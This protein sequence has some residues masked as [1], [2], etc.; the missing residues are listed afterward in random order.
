MADRCTHAPQSGSKL[1]KIFFILSDRFLFVYEPKHDQ[2][3]S[4]HIKFTF[5]Y[6][7]IN[8]INLFNTLIRIEESKFFIITFLR[9]YIARHVKHPT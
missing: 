8:L 1:F 9:D 7:D 6:M 5:R 3:M 4:D 2:V